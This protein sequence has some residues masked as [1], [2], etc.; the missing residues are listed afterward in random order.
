MSVLITGATGLIGGKIVEILLSEK[1]VVHYLTT[2][3][4]KIENR[5]DFKGFYWNPALQEIDVKAFDGVHTIIHLAGASV[6]KPWTKKYK[7]EILDSRTHSTRLLFE[8]LKSNDH[9]VTHIIAASGISIY[10]SS[11]DKMYYENETS[12]SSSFLGKVSEEWELGV[13]IFS[14]LDITISKVRTGI[15][16]DSNNGALPQILKPIKFGAGAALGS[17]N[18]WQSWIHIN[19][20]VGIYLYIMKNRLQGVFNGVAPG[21]LSNEK[22]TK[23]L[24]SYLKKPLWLP[25]V[26]AFVLKMILG[27]RSDL[28]L[29]SQLVS[30]DK[31]MEEG[32]KFQY[33]N[34]ESA[35]KDLL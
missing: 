29:E 30:A 24:A 14:E 12:L 18:Q 9:T 10:P 16:L 34:F 5:S 31:I 6:S 19:D 25:K 27:E 7:Q 33:V 22:M 11:K 8:A 17:G 1:K 26:P 28:V 3:K 35:L 2:R 32:Y 20:I 13:E 4:D 21:P 15:V 23:Q